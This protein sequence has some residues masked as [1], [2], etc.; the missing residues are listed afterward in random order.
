[1]VVMLTA[2]KAT[3]KLLPTS[4]TLQMPQKIKQAPVTSELRPGNEVQWAKPI[5]KNTGAKEPPRTLATPQP[6]QEISTQNGTERE[7]PGNSSGTWLSIGLGLSFDSY[8]E[9]NHPDYFASNIRLN[10]E[11]HYHIND[12]WELG[13]S[14]FLTTV[15]MTKT[16]PSTLR[17]LGAELETGYRCYA[18]RK[19]T[20]KIFAGGFYRTMLVTDNAFG[21][22]NLAGP[23]LFPRLEY[24][25]TKGTLLGLSIKYSPILNNLKF[26]SSNR[27]ISVSLSARHPSGNGL[28]VKLQ[29]SNLRME[30]LPI[31]SSL[32]SFLITGGYAW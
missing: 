6:S 32:S 28:V 14:A 20:V 30:F 11:L 22:K 3:L 10:S 7:S 1:M 9:T 2:T 15:P 27:E 16:Q 17:L 5:S 26:N 8:R 18:T 21:V 25:A 19:V 4:K 31:S 24:L 29:Y 23:E 13:A 12:A